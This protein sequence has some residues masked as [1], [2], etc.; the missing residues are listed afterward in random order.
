MLPDATFVCTGVQAIGGLRSAV[1]STAYFFPA[2][3]PQLSSTLA[4]LRTLCVKLGAGS[5]STAIVS[6]S[7]NGGAP[8]SVTRTLNVFV[9]T[10]AGVQLKMPLPL[11]IVAPAGAP[12]SR[13]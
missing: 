10:L 1:A 6:K 3:V 12:A 7:L 13:L 9:P 8:L 5:T 11:P 2:R 4:P